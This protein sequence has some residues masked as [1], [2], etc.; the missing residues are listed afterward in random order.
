MG[1]ECSTHGE[2]RDLYRVLMGKLRERDH[3][4]DPGID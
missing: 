2:K 1:G 4:G 3:V